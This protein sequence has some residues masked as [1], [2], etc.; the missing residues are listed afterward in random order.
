MIRLDT[1]S[2][3]TSLAISQVQPSP[4]YKSSSL[5]I[6]SNTQ[7]LFGGITSQ[8]KMVSMMEIPVWQYNS[9]AERP[10]ITTL[11]TETIEER[12]GSLMLPVFSQFNDFTSNQTLTNFEVS[13]VFMMGGKTS[14]NNDAFP[15]FASLNVSTN[16]WQW[17]DL[18]NTVSLAN[19]NN[20][21]LLSLDSIIAAGMI[22]DTLITIKNS[23]SKSN[24]SKRSTDLDYIIHLYNSTSLESVSSIDYKYSSS[25]STV[26]IVSHS[27][28]SLTI[29]LSVIIP[30]LVIIILACLLAWLYKRYKKK[31]EDERHEKEVKEIV[32]FYE[33]QHKQLSELT[34][35][36]YDSDYKSNGSDYNF[37]NS[38]DQSLNSWRK[39]RHDFEQQKNLYNVIR[40]RI[41]SMI[42]LNSGGS[43]RRSLSVASNFISQSLKRNNSTQSS[44]ATFITA[45][46]NINNDELEKEKME[47][48]TYDF[49]DSDI[50]YYSNSTS[51]N[52]FQNDLYTIHSDSDV[53]PS[54]L[55]RP[56]PAVPKHTD[57]L[58]FPNRTSSTL[59]HIPEDASISTFHSQN[60]GFIPMKQAY[61][62]QQSYMKHLSQTFSIDSSSL[63]NSSSIYTKLSKRPLSMSSGSISSNN[64]FHNNKTISHINSQYSEDSL[65]QKISQN[66]HSDTGSI[67]ED[68]LNNMEVQVLVGSKRR[69]KL[70][71]VNPDN[72]EEDEQ[73]GQQRQQNKSKQDNEQ[74]PFVDESIIEEKPR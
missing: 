19:N 35:S 40:P 34:F 69:T 4:F 73:Q 72:I 61:S 63:T 12:T 9:W 33:H 17:Q 64:N 59:N 70:R 48:N 25:S 71:V 41:D 43:I 27:S 1:N 10:A 58:T 68:E 36:S 42:N 67:S 14:E 23:S 20:S 47:D 55:I 52:P 5:Q 13:S 62:P 60:L 54:T 26:L 16:I 45:K 51:E 50:N 29:A 18:S 15:Q 46:T 53:L 39:K 24:F 32:D 3:T 65:T 6:N 28:K 8:N 2:W 11:S 37:E 66:D 22:Y 31:K 30:I 57:L 44:I 74:D 7:A 56:P 21:K 38:D 49:N